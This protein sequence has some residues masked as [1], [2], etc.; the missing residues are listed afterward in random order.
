MWYVER[1]EMGLNKFFK[2]FVWIWC[3]SI[4]NLIVI[5]NKMIGFLDK[6]LGDEISW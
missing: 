6:K 3:V 2:Y 5:R 4:S 1:V